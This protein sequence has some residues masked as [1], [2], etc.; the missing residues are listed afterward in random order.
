MGRAIVVEPWEY[1]QQTPQAV[2]TPPLCDGRAI[3]KAAVTNGTIGENAGFFS[4]LSL[5]IGD[6]LAGHPALAQFRFN[7]V[8]CIRF[9]PGT[10]YGYAVEQVFRR[11]LANVPSHPVQIE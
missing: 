3:A 4:S 2:P 8:Q 9:H 10:V 7:Y 1:R 5:V 6:L 11:G